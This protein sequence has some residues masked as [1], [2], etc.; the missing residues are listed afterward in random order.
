MGSSTN[1]GAVVDS[2]GRVHGVAGLRIVYDSI[3]PFATNGNANGPI[4]MIAEKQSD[5]ILGNPALPRVETEF[6]MSQET[7]ATTVD[8]H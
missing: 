3:M 7:G 5:A 2:F 1:Q 8:V 4:N 6:W